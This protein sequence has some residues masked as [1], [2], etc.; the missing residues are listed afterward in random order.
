MVVRRGGAFMCDLKTMIKFGA[1]IAV[2]FVLGFVF[3]PSLRAVIS[4]LR[5]LLYLQYVLW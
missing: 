4:V 5:H 1:V 2:P 3:F